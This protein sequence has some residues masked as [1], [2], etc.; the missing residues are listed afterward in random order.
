MSDIYEWKNRRGIYLILVHTYQS[1]TYDN[2]ILVNIYIYIGTFN[3]VS[4]FFYSYENIQAFN[5]IYV[6]LSNV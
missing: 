1:Y 2:I 3:C 4:A 5:Y 6:I